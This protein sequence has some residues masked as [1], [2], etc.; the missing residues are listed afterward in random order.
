VAGKA[1]VTA[2]IPDTPGTLE[3]AKLLRVSSIKIGEALQVIESLEDG[4]FDLVVDTIGGRDI[5]QACRRL[6]TQDGQV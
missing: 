6:F 5:W 4:S 1:T 2:Q 3:S